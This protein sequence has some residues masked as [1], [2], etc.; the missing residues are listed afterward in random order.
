[1]LIINKL[2]KL[3]DFVLPFGASPEFTSAY[4]RSEVADYKTLV[5]PAVATVHH[6]PAC[7]EEIEMIRDF[8]KIV[9]GEDKDVYK[10]IN[11]CIKNV[12]VLEALLESAKTG[13]IVTLN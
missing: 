11:N 12:K 5:Y 10:W 4:P 13:S 1:M 8:G 7:V 3:D 9:K 2:L 6:P